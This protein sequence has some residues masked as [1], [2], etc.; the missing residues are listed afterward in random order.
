MRLMQGGNSFS[1][2]ELLAKYYILGALSR[3]RGIADELP[4]HLAVAKKAH[5]GVEAAMV[6]RNT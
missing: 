2:E 4:W 5:A 6:E 3:A 1:I